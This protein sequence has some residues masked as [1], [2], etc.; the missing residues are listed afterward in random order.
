MG[1]TSL[2]MSQHLMSSIFSYTGEEWSA[3]H[4]VLIHSQHSV[5]GGHVRQ[6]ACSKEGMFSEHQ[7]KERSS[8]DKSLSLLSTAC[9]MYYTIRI[10]IL[11]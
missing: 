6:G 9:H 1:R 2:E 8:V 7:L 3:S 5:R 10:Y 4:S 11:S